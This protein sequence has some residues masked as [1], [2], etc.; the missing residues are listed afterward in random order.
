MSPRAL[1]LEADLSAPSLLVS[2]RPL[3]AKIADQEIMLGYRRARLASARVS[4]MT[5]RPDG[6]ILIEF[7]PGEDNTAVIEYVPATG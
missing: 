7:V 4:T 5:A 6:Y 1:N 2:I 3:I